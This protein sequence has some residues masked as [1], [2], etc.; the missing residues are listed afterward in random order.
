VLDELGWHCRRFAD[1]AEPRPSAA[2]QNKRG[3]A[4]HAARLGIDE[5]GLE[6]Q[7]AQQPSYDAP[8]ASI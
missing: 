4:D 6:G 1:R 5:T 8:S 2:A 3:F 7:A